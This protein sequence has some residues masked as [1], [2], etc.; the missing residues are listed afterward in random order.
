VVV[1]LLLLAGAG[2][3]KATSFIFSALS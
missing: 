2:L 3:D 1:G